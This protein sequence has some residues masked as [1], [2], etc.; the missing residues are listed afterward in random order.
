LT[1]ESPDL[2]IMDLMVPG[3]SGIE[4]LAAVRQHRPLATLPVLVT[5]GSVTSAYDLRD[6][7]LVRVIHKPFELSSVLRAAQKLLGSSA[8]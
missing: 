6:F 7:G 4:V 2:L 5:T 3:V 8:S 1:H